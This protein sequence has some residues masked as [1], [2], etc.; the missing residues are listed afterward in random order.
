TAGCPAP[1][2]K[3]P[4]MRS[5]PFLA[6]LCLAL[7]PAPL[8]AAKDGRKPNV[9]VLLADDLGYADLG[10][11][12]ARDVATPHI[13]SLAKHGVRCTSGYVSAPV[14]SPSRAGL[15][16]GRYQQRFGH[17]FNPAR[18]RSGGAGQG[19]PP[20]ERTLADALRAAGYVTGLVGKWHLGEE[21]VFH[22]QKRGFDEFYG[23]LA[24]QH[25]YLDADDRDAGPILRGRQ[26]AAAD[27]YLTDV[28]AREA[29]R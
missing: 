16:T 21:E 23:F 25:S 13:D 22:P 12:G 14:C 10:V 2:G 7:L 8:H 9:I 24:G 17:E 1:R 28:F 4:L 15:L 26:K 11:Q 19:L 18:L 5:T 20:D 6:A 27:G 3:E 29:V